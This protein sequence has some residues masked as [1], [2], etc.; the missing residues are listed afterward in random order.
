VVQ[1]ELIGVTEKDSHSIANLAPICDRE[2]FALTEI[3][4]GER[5]TLPMSNLMAFRNFPTFSLCA[6]KLS[7]AALVT[8]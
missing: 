2:N 6:S 7:D 4:S 3:R 5:D 1:K 8:Q